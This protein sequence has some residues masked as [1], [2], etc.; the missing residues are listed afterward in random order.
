VLFIIVI[1]EKDVFFA[2]RISAMAAERGK[3]V[4]FVSNAGDL[5]KISGKKPELI[6][7]DLSVISPAAIKLVKKGRTRIIGYIEKKD[8]KLEKKAEKSCDAVITKKEFEKKLPE[9][10]SKL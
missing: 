6:V 3:Q 1:A 7:A 5:K 10:L 4:Q 9:L 2:A 8:R